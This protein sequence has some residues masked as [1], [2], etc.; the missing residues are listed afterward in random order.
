MPTRHR[1]TRKLRGSR[2]H[3]WGRVGQHRK[4]GGKGGAGK[5]GL[6]KHKWSFTVKYLPDKFKRDSLPPKK[7]SKPRKW[8]NVGQLD[9]L[10]LALE[11]RGDARTLEGLPVLDLRSLEYEKLL[12]IGH[13][14]QPY[15]V[16]VDKCTEG[17][18]SKIVSVGG[19]VECQPLKM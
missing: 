15:Y 1:K 17:A 6:H 11:S 2:T 4:T 14:R 3:G 18:R 9:A 16:I 13:V 5:S 7:Q 19:R 12:G 10:F 8:I